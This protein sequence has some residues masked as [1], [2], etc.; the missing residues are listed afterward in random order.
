MK[1]F[2]KHCDFLEWRRGIPKEEI[3]FVPTMGNL[4]HGHLSLIEKSV[5]NNKYTLIS[6]YVNPKQFGPSED[7]KTY[8]RTLYKDCEEIHALEIKLKKTYP[9]IETIIF[10]PESNEEIYPKGYSTNIY[11]SGISEKLCGLK[12]PGHFEGVTTVVFRLF[13]IIDPMNAYFGQKDYQQYLIIK[14][15]VTDLNVNV[16]L[17]SCPIVRDDDGLALSSRNQF[18]SLDERQKALVLPKTIRASSYIFSNND[19]QQSLIKF[20]KLKAESLKNNDFEYLEI[21]DAESLNKVTPES[22]EILIAGAYKASKAR[23]IDNT[24]VKNSNV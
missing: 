10:S 12:R 7:Y 8:P 9:E 3:G 4:H 23:L 18:L 19:F 20:K 5:K 14:K 24:I 21:Y 6:I 17:S 2:K 1:I 11:V 15:M 22:K 16:Q 13:S